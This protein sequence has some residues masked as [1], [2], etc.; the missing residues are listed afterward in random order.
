MRFA[1]QYFTNAL[2]VI[3]TY[4]GVEPL[5]FYLKNHFAVNKK[6]GS[7]DRKSIS[8]FCYCYYRLGKALTNLPA[9]QRLT[10]ALFLCNDDISGYT[11]LFEES[12]Q[13]N[14]TSHLDERIKFI[15]TI[16]PHFA[17]KFIFSF[18][19]EL[20]ETIDAIEFAKS[21]LIQPDVYMRIRPGNQSTVITKLNAAEIAFKNISQ[22]CLAFNNATKLNSIIEI[23]KEAVVQDL[24]SQRVGEF[25]ETVATDQPINQS[26]SVW[27][28][29][30]A[31]GGKSIL[32]YDILNKIDLTV[33]D[34]RPFILQNLKN[35]FATA[36]IKNYKAFVADL[37][38]VTE[39]IKNQKTH[40]D[41]IICDVP[42]SGSGT[43]GRSPEQLYFYKNDKTAYYASLQKNIITNA[44]K[45]L[46]K[47]GYFLYIT[48]SVFK[49]ENEF[50]VAFIQQHL[51]LKLIKTEVL[52]GYDN[53]AD[54]MFAALF[55][56]VNG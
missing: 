5:H 43:W 35:R 18:A 40:F 53:K 51:K 46:N 36:R 28:C 27:D 7:K 12:W 23:D 50:A 26:T 56:S 9:A 2:A 8:H 31:S 44:I 19:D 22:T 16:Y 42:C 34:L 11:I 14:H 47:S 10:V 38:Q 54:T 15:K 49:Q 45:Q 13:Q 33:S 6:F 4:N 29:C 24:S 20:S 21:H 3:N 39:P 41:L 17:I 30:A 32:A 37:A 52:K 25:L 55:Q 1:Q 48:C